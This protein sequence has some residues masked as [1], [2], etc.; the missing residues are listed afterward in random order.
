[1]LKGENVVGS[2][3][4]LQGEFLATRALT[5]ITVIFDVAQGTAAARLWCSQT[6]V[7]SGTADDQPL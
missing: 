2:W 7:C 3:R 6:R 5:A 4:L 1:M